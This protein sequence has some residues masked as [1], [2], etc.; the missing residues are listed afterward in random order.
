MKKFYFF[1]TFLLIAAFANAETVT[2]VITASDLAATGTAYTDFSNVVK[3]SGAAYAGNSAKNTAGAIQMRSKNSNSGIVSTTSAGLVKSV[4]IK[5]ASGT[6]TIDVYGSNTAYEAATDLYNTNKN[7]KQGK[8]IGSLTSTGTITFTEDY[9]Y[10][11]IR[12][13]SGVIYISSIA[14]EWEGQGGS[15]ETIA[16]PV[17]TPESGNYSE[18]QTVTITAE[19]GTTIDYTVTRNGEEYASGIDATSP[20]SLDLPFTIQTATWV[21]SAK[22]KKGEAVSAETT[23]T[24]N[25]GGTLVFEKVTNIGELAATDKVILV[26]ESGSKY[27]AV[28][29]QGSSA[30]TP[31]KVT[32]DADGRITITAYKQDLSLKDVAI[33][34]LKSEVVDGG[35]YYTFNDFDYQ[36]ETDFIGFLAKGGNNTNLIMKTNA[37]QEYDTY[38]S[39]DIQEDE[40]A[41]IASKDYNTRG[42][43]Y[44]ISAETFK[45][46]SLDNATGSGYAVPFLY[47]INLELS[48]VETNVVK[49]EADVKAIA[50]GIV[51]NATEATNVNV[52]NFTGQAVKA[53]TVGNGATTIALPRGMYIV[54]A[55]AKATKVVVR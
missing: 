47:H 37:T 33:F 21:I 38:W 28:G 43:L 54:R 12:S 31:I 32:P 14:I 30:R 9:K 11:G 7:N 17:I 29:P 52:Y 26:A 42:I 2:D 8:K 36:K 45:S 34:Q 50:G 48:G 22:A 20:V 5:V 10:V 6:N 41:L 19:E 16:A 23:N 27:Y 4:T 18:E 44:S 55:G 49:A 51:V 39:I 35:T 3:T 15:T 53:T 24:I 1:F 46:Y 13:N 40:T 25:I